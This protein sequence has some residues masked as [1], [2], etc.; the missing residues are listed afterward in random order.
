MRQ[1]RHPLGL[2]DQADGV[3]RRHLE[4]G[5]PRGP[6]L[7]QKA[8]EGLVQVRTETRLHKRARHVRPARRL[9]VRQREYGFGG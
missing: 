1:H 6:V 4:L 2:V 7:L 8:L 5:N 9:A 3:A